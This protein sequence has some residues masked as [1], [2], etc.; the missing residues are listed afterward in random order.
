MFF[1]Q[2]DSGLFDENMLEVSVHQTQ[3]VKRIAGKPK[4]TSKRAKNKK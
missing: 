4:S 2:R 1:L 3:V